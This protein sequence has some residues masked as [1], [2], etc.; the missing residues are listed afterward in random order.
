MSTQEHPLGVS[1]EF[2]P[3]NTDAGREK[4]AGVRDALAA[5]N[6]RFFSVTYGAGG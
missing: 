6:P 2:F 5:R 1:F 3:P 4:L